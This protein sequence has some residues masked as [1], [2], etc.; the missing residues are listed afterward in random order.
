LILAALGLAIIAGCAALGLEPPGPK[1]QVFF[2]TNS[3]DIHARGRSVIQAAANAALHDASR[4]TVIGK[5]DRAGPPSANMALSQRRAD[6]VRNALISAGVP[7]S[8]IDTRWSGE[9]RPEVTTP[10]DTAEPRNRVVDIIVGS[11]W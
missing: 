6:A 11:G 3:A 4:V 7:V 10:D 8:R 1:Y 2:E 9:N 5:T